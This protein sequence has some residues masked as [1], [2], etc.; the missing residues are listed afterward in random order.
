MHVL[1]EDESVAVMLAT[2]WAKNKFPRK[3]LGVRVINFSS[4]TTVLLKQ[5]CF[6]VGEN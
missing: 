2:V 4:K 3:M 6:V 5:I 1:S